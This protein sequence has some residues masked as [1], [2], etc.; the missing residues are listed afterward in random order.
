M[1]YIFDET[2]KCFNIPN[3]L[4]FLFWYSNRDYNIKHSMINFIINIIFIPYDF[5][6][7]SFWD[8]HFMEVKNVRLTKIFNSLSY[9]T[10]KIV[11]TG[12]YSLHCTNNIYNWCYKLTVN[13]K[14]YYLT[15]CKIIIFYK[16]LKI[17]YFLI[18]VDIYLLLY[19]IFK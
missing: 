2:L 10:H 13:V 7:L 8:L 18:L 17:I 14:W 6:I 3:P 11:R 15:T 1:L 12:S 9:C 4:N 5:N 16:L 19:I